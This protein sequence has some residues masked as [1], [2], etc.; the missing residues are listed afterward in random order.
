M[1]NM[2]KITK[3]VIDLEI[4][5]LNKKSIYVEYHNG[6][7]TLYDNGVI[8]LDGTAKEIYMYLCGMKYGMSIKSNKPSQEVNNHNDLSDPSAYELLTGNKKETLKLQ[9]MTNSIAFSEILHNY[10]ICIVD[11]DLNIVTFNTAVYLQNDG[12][13]VTLG[14]NP[15]LLYD[16]KVQVLDKMTV[17]DFYKLLLRAINV[18]VLRKCKTD[19]GFMKYL[20]WVSESDLWY[21]NERDS[22]YLCDS[23]NII[24]V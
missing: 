7:Y 22:K 9:A 5:K 18:E 21:L 4:K 11:T 15:L 8:L 13:S 2:A 3:Q 1:G 19:K 24:R 14:K 23:V 20:L 16:L 6:Y 12:N 17:S 10:K